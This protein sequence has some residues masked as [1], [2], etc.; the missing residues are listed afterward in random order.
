MRLPTR[1]VFTTPA[2][3]VDRSNKLRRRND[4][5]VSAVFLRR[6]LAAHPDRVFPQSAHKKIDVGNR[7]RPEGCLAITCQ[8]KQP[9][10]ARIKNRR[11]QSTS[12]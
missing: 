9:V 12:A 7:R 2:S 8:Q 11:R 10:A 4:N 1:D 3:S 6:D 5:L